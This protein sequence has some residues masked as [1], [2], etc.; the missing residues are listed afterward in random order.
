MNVEAILEQRLQVK[1][2]LYI[3]RIIFGMLIGAA[4]IT[5]M[6]RFVSLIEHLLI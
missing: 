6:H 3:A 5:L 1:I 4:L 2:F